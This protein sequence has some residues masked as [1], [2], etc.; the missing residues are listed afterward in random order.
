MTSMEAVE[1]WARGLDD[2]V[3]RIAPRFRRTEARQRVRSYLGGLLAPLERKNGWHL[4]EAAGDA[5][6]D[7]VQDFLSRMRWDADG[8][9]DDLRAYVVEHLGDPDA[10]LV[11]DETGFVKKGEHSVGV[12]R[13]YSGTA[14]RIENCQIGVFLGYASRHGRALMDRAL[15]L[16][17]TWAD[18]VERRRAAWVPEAVDFAT[19]PKLAIALLERTLEAGVPCAWV[20]ADSVYGGDSALRRFLE[21]RQIGYVLAVTRGQH[22]GLRPGLDWIEEVP[23][24]GWHRLSAGAGAKGP[25]RYDWA[26]LSFRG[27]APEGWGKGLLIR[28]SLGEDQELAFYLTVAPPGT[29]LADLVRVAGMR[30]TLEEGF[31]AAKGEVGLDQYEVRS[32]TGWYRHITLAMLALAYLTVVRKAAIGGRGPGRPRRRSAASHRAGGPAP[33][34]PPRSPDPLRSRRRYRLVALATASPAA[35][36]SVPLEA[37]HPNR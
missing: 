27:A 9:R 7:A 26:F 20:T 8:V 24:N 6:P 34:V 28:R 36:T 12:Q 32:W 35:G 11:V 16:P 18:D 30:W 25:R 22:L 17:R 21:Q 31:E 3:E 2:V 19:K 10:V 4:A 33:V 1:D 23:A 37:T 29:T 13:Q 5:S 14:G 15:Y